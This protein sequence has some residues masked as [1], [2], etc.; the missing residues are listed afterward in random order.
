MK[1]KAL[2]EYLK[3]YL[4]ADKFQ[5]YA[6]NGLQ[7]EG[8]DDIRKIALGVSASLEL[9]EKA[10]AIGADALLVHHG[11]F[12]KGEPSPVVGIKRRRLGALIESNMNLIAFHLPLDAHP[13]VGNNAQL[14]RLLGL[15]T[16]SRTGFLDLLHVGTLIDGEMTAAAFAERV[17][18]V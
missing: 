3:T 2:V 17:A 4:E 5:D 9:I 6:P 13:T 12:W 7:V 15:K 11:W 10:A 14:A 18:R 1:T 8:K 16:E